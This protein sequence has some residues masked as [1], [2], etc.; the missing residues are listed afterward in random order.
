MRRASGLLMAVIIMILLALPWAFLGTATSLFIDIMVVVAVIL[1]DA[2]NNRLVSL[3]A[4]R[5]SLR[6]PATT[7]LVVGGLLVGTAIV[8][9]TFAVSDTMDNLIVGQVTEGMGEVDLVI[10]SDF[11]TSYEFANETELGDLSADLANLDGFEHVHPVAMESVVM[12]NTRTGLSSLSNTALGFENGSARDFGGFYSGGLAFSNVPSSGQAYIPANLALDLD[13]AEGDTL[14]LIRGND[15]LPLTVNAIIDIDGLGAYR[16]GGD[17]FSSPFTVFVNKTD[18]QMWTGN[19]GRSNLLFVE[20]DRQVPID[21][22]GI[23]TVLTTSPIGGLEIVQDRAGMLEDG[24]EGL[25]A[26]ISLFF[27]FGS[28]SV[29]AGM[30]L[31]LNIF[32]MLAEERKSEMGITRAIGLSRTGLRRLFVYE[33]VVYATIASALGT[34][35]GILVAYLIILSASNVFGFTDIGIVSYFTFTPEGLAYSYLIGFAI[36]M[37]TVY[38][39]TTRVSRMNIVR[40][41][42]NIPEPPV[43]PKDRRAFITGLLLLVGGAL[44]VVIGVRFENLGASM[45]GVS[46]CTLSLGLLL[47]RF[48]SDRIAWNVAGA[49]T[50]AIWTGDVIGFKPFPYEAEVELLVVA[51]LFLLT[52]S[53]ILVMFNSDAIIRVLT[54]VIRARSSYRAVVR[55]A[56]S[57][58]LKAKFRTGLSIFIFGLVIFTV[59]I[60]SMVSGVMNYN[61]PI[62]VE[63]T[64]GGFDTIAFTL[65]PRTVIDTD[66]WERVNSTAG[67]LDG[68]NISNMV[69][70]ATIGVRV[71]DTVDLGN[72]NLRHVEFDV[73]AL[74]VNRAFYTEGYYPLS[75]WD[76]SRFQTEDEVWEGIMSNGSLVVI[77]GGLAGAMGGFMQF[78]DA[79]SLVLNDNF[80]VVA[81]DGTRTNVTVVG[82]MKQSALGGV[83]INEDAVYSSFK[84]LGINRL[85]VSYSEGLDPAVQSI[86]L[87]KE[88]L[89]VGLST[90]S[91][92]SLAEDITS[93]V[94]SIFTL[95]RA[96]LAMGLIIGIVGLGIITIRSIYERRLEIGMMR[97]IGFTKAMV[98]TNF[99]LESAFISM[100]GIVAGSLLGILVGYQLFVETLMEQ[101]FI[102]VI[103][104]QPIL[105]VALLAFGATMLSILPAARGASKVSPAEVLRFE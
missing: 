1:L 46:L 93:S 57:Y 2:Y 55:T 35:L 5:Y 58:P 30:A 88:F 4:V 41:I 51:G 39:A 98:V 24:R 17:G 56:I 45:S 25:S 79:D 91:V 70:M 22:P 64:S 59:T 87:E 85:L 6:R 61:I 69:A 86:L 47:R 7:A 52:S 73:L 102:F 67:P 44:T 71:N 90:I 74:G 9:A 77:D 23:E 3:M 76:R 38:F 105:F 18:L 95:F 100:L 16:F 29:I 68:G 103:D 12:L 72:G 101:D 75:D 8:S 21:Y 84:A 92:K 96:F 28:F 53:L 104:W 32:T 83:F 34:A 50:L 80:T 15:S 81:W 36:T 78:D 10:A 62:M 14:V 66:P 99:A 65:D 26:F 31:V 48:V 89:Y 43:P 49:L 60:L 13:A 11:V 82:V 63:E 97:A 20:L 19:P 94:D 42:R 54:T 27:V 37:A 40:A 33:G